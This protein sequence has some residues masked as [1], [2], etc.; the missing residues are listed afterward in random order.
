MNRR[1]LLK[2]L[3]AVSTLALLPVTGCAFSVTGMLNT[4]IS[5][6]SAILSYVGASQPWA[7]SVQAALTALQNAIAQWKAGGA[8]TLIIDAL[9]T[10][11][12]VLAAIPLTAVY[13]PLIDV[14]VAGIEAIINYFAPAKLS[15]AQNP[16]RG[17]VIL[18]K[19]TALQS[20]QGAFKAQYNNAAV[21]V[22]LPQLKVA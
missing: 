4:I 6:L 17:H 3:A 21:G 20:Y 16:H 1:T 2:S 11:E 10:V 15:N 9:N 18:M 7:A 12:A 8:S 13:S 22:G 14:I 19:P 5:A